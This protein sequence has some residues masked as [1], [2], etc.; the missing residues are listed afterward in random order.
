MIKVLHNALNNNEINSMLEE[1]NSFKEYISTSM[2]KAGPGPATYIIDELMYGF[3]RVG[4]N[5]YKHDKPY[6]PHT[7]HKEKWG[8]TIN[9]VV[10]LSSTDPD[11]SLI[12]FNQ[13]YHKD[14][15][16]WCLH[17][18]VMPFEVNTG[19]AGRPCDYDVENLTNK[20]I[21]DDLYKWLSWAPKDQWFGL[22]G[23]RLNFIPGDLLI[24]DNKYIHATG[25]LKGTKVGLSLRYKR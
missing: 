21:D 20:P 9:V 2:N 22:T 18:D 8:E 12:V 10:P 16:T 15:V 5:Y 11:A 13:K 7:D 19:V 4:G 23:Q 1:Y 6:F 24:F 17:H 25:I 3:T 14:S